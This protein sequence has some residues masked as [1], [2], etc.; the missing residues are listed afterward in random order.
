[1]SHK[2]DSL[3]PI[4]EAFSCLFV[5]AIHAASPQARHHFTRFDQVNQLVGASEADAAV[6]FWNATRRLRQW[7]SRKHKV[8]AGN[9]VRFP[10]ERLWKEWDLTRLGPRTA[11]FPWARV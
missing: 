11:S 7:L 2:R 1:M 10:D 9:T 4:G 6:G 3:V 8:R 5:K